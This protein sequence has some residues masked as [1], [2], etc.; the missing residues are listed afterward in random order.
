MLP[1]ENE[2]DQPDINAFPWSRL[3]KKLPVLTLSLQ[4]SIS[5]PHNQV[6]YGCDP[7]PRLLDLNTMT[8][9]DMRELEPR[10]RYM[11]EWHFQD[12]NFR[13]EVVD[14]VTNV[15]RFA[16]ID[17][18]HSLMN[19]CNLEYN[20]ET[21]ELLVMLFPRVDTQLF[22]A[23][24]RAATVSSEEWHRDPH[25]AIKLE[26]VCDWIK[27]IESTWPM[28][29]IAKG[30]WLFVKVGSQTEQVAVLVSL[31]PG[32]TFHYNF[33]PEAYAWLNSPNFPVALMAQI[34]EVD[35]VTWM[36]TRYFGKLNK[37]TAREPDQYR[38]VF[39]IFRL[40]HNEEQPKFVRCF[41]PPNMVP[42]IA[43]WSQ[44]DLTKYRI[45]IAPMLQMAIS[46]VVDEHARKKRGWPQDIVLI[47][48]KK[49]MELD[50]LEKCDNV[51][52]TKRLLINRRTWVVPVYTEVLPLVIY[53][54]VGGEIIID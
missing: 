50:W 41:S 19:R 35:G 43:M 22:M 6:G 29:L 14:T 9:A 45:N 36:C 17:H 37:N 40:D 24:Y 8:Q 49:L 4:E 28:V 33:I 53:P 5:E 48:V 15:R 10:R 39:T 21:E 47:V 44:F 38:A 31:V 54:E 7:F 11:I 27:I 26:E 46:T 52:C 34:V 13:I 20:P 32:S 3:G 2:H 18:T 51:L 23:I 16:L 1:G 30:G 42:K 25:A 12:Q